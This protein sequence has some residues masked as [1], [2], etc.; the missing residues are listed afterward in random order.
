MPA[1]SPATATIVDDLSEQ[2][3]AA[4]AALEVTVARLADASAERIALDGDHRKRT[5]ER[6]RYDELVADIG[7]L[8]RDRARQ[9]AEARRIGEMLRDQRRRL[10]RE[11]PSGDVDSARL[12]V[13]TAR[14][15][16]DELVAE[17]AAL[18]GRMAEALANGAPD[19]VARVSERGADLA[20]LVVVARLNLASAEATLYEAQADAMGPDLNAA[21]D[22]L[23]AAVSDEA[24]ARVRVEAA[25]AVSQSLGARHRK[26][27]SSALLA[28]READRVRGSIK[29]EVN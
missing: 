25:R 23:R 27:R 17:R 18:P 19:S 26:L 22:E 4:T 20:S 14:Q 2:H 28:R 3:R 21:D 13:D 12:D 8:S 9:A 7:N 11:H 5:Q 10:D 6:A 24:E 1:K 29:V 15:R 16:V